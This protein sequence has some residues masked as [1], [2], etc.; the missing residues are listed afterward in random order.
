MGYHFPELTGGGARRTQ[1]A[2]AADNSPYP[3]SDAT[4]GRD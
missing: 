1:T 3:L 2:A 4:P